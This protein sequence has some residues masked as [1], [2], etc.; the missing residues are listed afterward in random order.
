MH[1][2]KKGR[3]TVIRLDEN[4]EI[5]QSLLYVCEKKNIGSAMVRG[6][7]ALKAAELAHF[8]NKEKKYNSKVFEGMYEI[9]CL[10]GN[11][12]TFD[13]K[14]VVHLHM[15]IA[16]TEYNTYGGHVVQGIVSPTCEITIQE[17]STK[18]RR[19]KDVNSGL[20]LQRF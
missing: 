11:I 5:L 16:N 9:V 15:I 1:Y 14:P 18:V 13:E 7:G 10:T 17:L 12:T 20:N 4:D 2:K 8:D 3:E 19:E 6:I